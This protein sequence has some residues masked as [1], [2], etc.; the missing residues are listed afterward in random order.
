MRGTA[1]VAAL[2][3]SS[4]GAGA[5][6]YAPDIVIPQPSAPI[7]IESHAAGFEKAWGDPRTG[8]L[9]QVF[10]RNTTSRGVVAVDFGFVTAGVWNELLGQYAITAPR[11]RPPNEL[12]RENWSYPI[13]DPRKFHRSAV[14]VSRVRFED[15]EIWSF[16]PEAVL[17]AAHEALGLAEPPPPPLRVADEAV[18]FTAAYFQDG[19]WTIEEGA[20]CV[21]YVATRPGAIVA[22]I[23]AEGQRIEQFS[24]GDVLR[25]CGQTIHMPARRVGADPPPILP[26]D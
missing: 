6:D 10:W 4:A 2:V 23:T 7:A 21:H 13:R 12:Q 24:Q 25:V 16:N 1:L 19:A 3:L 15:G 22:M 11:L 14:F 26:Q 8:L 9:H 20:S 18:V 17:P 5:Q